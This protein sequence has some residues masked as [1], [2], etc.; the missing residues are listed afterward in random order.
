MMRRCST[1]SAN[2]TTRRYLPTFPV[3]HEQPWRLAM[4]ERVSKAT[5]NIYPHKE[6]RIA[7]LLW[8][9]EYAAQ[10]G[11]A[12]DFWDSLTDSQKQTCREALEQIEN[13]PKEQR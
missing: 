6:A 4:A 8:N 2:G 13:A 9:N 1:E 11:G 5:R 3:L 7:I 12:M 10:N